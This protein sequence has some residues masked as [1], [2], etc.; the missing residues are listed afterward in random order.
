MWGSSRDLLSRTGRLE[1]GLIT[2]QA[3]PFEG[4]C[5][6]GDRAFP[7]AAEGEGGLSG[8]NISPSIHTGLQKQVHFVLIMSGEDF[9]CSGEE[10][11]WSLGDEKGD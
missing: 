9:D 4:R 11:V 2:I 5:R 3:Y 8:Q 1:D 6:S 7:A 10:G